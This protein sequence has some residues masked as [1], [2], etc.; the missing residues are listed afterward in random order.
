MS[1]IST[2]SEELRGFGRIDPFNKVQSGVP[3]EN[4]ATLLE[5]A[6]LESPASQLNGPQVSPGSANQARA[7]DT[8]S[9]EDEDCLWKIIKGTV[10]RAWLDRRREEIARRLLLA[11]DWTNEES[12]GHCRL[13]CRWMLDRYETSLP[14]SSEGPH[15]RLLFLGAMQQVVEG[16]MESGE[17]ESGEEEEE[18][19]AE[20]EWR[21]VQEAEISWARQNERGRQRRR[22]KRQG[23]RGK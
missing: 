16:A 6:Q 7:S 4:P 8:M 9:R 10:E 14:L 3:I 19:D 2:L 18:D 12:K 15:R 11:A 1:D 5:A 13:I 22:R 23:Q 20:V 21:K 17:E